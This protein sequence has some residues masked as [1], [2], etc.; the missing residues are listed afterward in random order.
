MSKKKLILPLTKNHLFSRAYA[1]GKSDVSKLCAVYLLK[2][3]QKNPD[4][5]PAKTMLGITVNRKLG[6]A[7]R[8][9]RVKRLIREAYRDNYEYIKDGYIVVIAARAAAFGPQ[10]KAQDMSRALRSI[11]ARE[12][13]Y[14]L[15]RPT[16]RKS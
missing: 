4:G 16:M 1:K 15:K 11:V 9:N 14:N 6:K 7:C 2:N 10:V 13:F 12:D 8:R 5:S 3:Y